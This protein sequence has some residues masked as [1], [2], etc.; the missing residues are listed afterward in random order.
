MRIFAARVHGCVCMCL[1]VCLADAQT[2][3]E[4]CKKSVQ[5]IY[6]SRSTVRNF[7][8][9]LQ[10]NQVFTPI[11]NRQFRRFSPVYRKSIKIFSARTTC[12]QCRVVSTRNLTVQTKVNGYRVA[13]PAISRAK[14]S[15]IHS[16]FWKIGTNNRIIE[17][18]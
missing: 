8:C 14:L 4:F 12:T 13:C 6:I 1:C 10:Q 7:N 17:K 16:R 9:S 2:H 11:S 15:K 18:N 3:E 5:K